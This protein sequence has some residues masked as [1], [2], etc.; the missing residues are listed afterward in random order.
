[1]CSPP[2][3][4]QFSSVFITRRVHH[5]E[6]GSG[7]RE[8]LKSAS[9]RRSDDARR[10]HRPLAVLRSTVSDRRFASPRPP[11][12]DPGVLWTTGQRRSLGP[13][14]PT[15]VG[16]MRN[17]VTHAFVATF[18][19]QPFRLAVSYYTYGNFFI[20]IYANCSGRRDVGQEN[21]NILQHLQSDRRSGSSTKLLLNLLIRFYLNNV[22][23]LHQLTSHSTTSCLTT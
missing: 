16:R 5:A 12:A 21:V 4:V 19:R 20:P 8:Q 11:A 2:I 6:L 10:R 13:S 3:A 23:N 18:Q 1:V 17:H 7:R 22:I 15:H 9:Y 14:S